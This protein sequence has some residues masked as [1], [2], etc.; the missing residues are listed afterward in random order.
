MIK[1]WL[2]EARRIC[3]CVGQF[4]TPWLGAV[5][6]ICVLLLFLTMQSARTP[7]GISNSIKTSASIFDAKADR[8]EL[9]YRE[10]ISPLISEY[11][12]SNI[13]AAQRAIDRIHAM[14][15]GYRENIP[16]FVEDITGWGTRFGVITRMPG[17]YWYEDDRVTKYVTS[18]FE[19]RLFTEETFRNDIE[20]IL[21]QFRD[22]L[23]AN[24]NHLLAGVTEELNEAEGHVYQEIDPDYFVHIAHERMASSIAVYG[25]DSLMNGVISMV[26]GETAGVIAVQLASRVVIGV[27]SHLATATA[28]SGGT[29]AAGAG[30]GSAAGTFGGPVGIGVGL[31]V[32][33]LIGA[34][35]DI[36][37]TSE[38]RAKLNT[39]MNYYISEIEKSLYIG[40]GTEVCL[41]DQLRF[42]VIDI[43]S[44]YRSVLEE[45][46]VG[47]E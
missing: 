18:K 47:A 32:G 4:P 14:L 31:V 34:G 20:R 42:A 40:T 37:M 35:V 36:Y 33:T 25:T 29:T 28:V 3:S 23:E 16:L 15:D 8:R 1:A 12:Q 2:N 7:S 5:L 11:E 38:Y 41:A 17:D 46:L 9:F 24:R 10:S 19:K 22:D 26:L 13:D 44:T 43:N 27:V 21:E 30:T 6:G 39:D 45:Y